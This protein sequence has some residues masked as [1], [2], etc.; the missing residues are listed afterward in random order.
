MAIVLRQSP[1]FP[2]E[3]INYKMKKTILLSGLI[4]L[5]SSFFFKSSAQKVYLS[6]Y[7][8]RG[9]KEG[10]RVNI[11]DNF[12]DSKSE[13]YLDVPR[14]K[15]F[16]AN[17]C[18]FI[19]ISIDKENLSNSN[20]LEVETIENDKFA[21]L[22]NDLPFEKLTCSDNVNFDKKVTKDNKYIYISG[23][24]IG[25]KNKIIFLNQ[26]EKPR[27][28]TV[29]KCNFVSF[30]TKNL[31]RLPNFIEINSNK[32]QLNIN[33]L[34][35]ND[36]RCYQNKTY[37]PVQANVI[38]SNSALSRTNNFPVSN[39][40]PI[41]TANNNTFGFNKN[42][43]NISKMPTNENICIDRPEMAIYYL[44]TNPSNI[45]EEFLTDLWGNIG[46]SWGDG[47]NQAN[48]HLKA[49]TYHEKIGENQYLVKYTQLNETKTSYTILKGNYQVI[50]S[51]NI[52][53]QQPNAIK[54]DIQMYFIKNQ[55]IN[56][57]GLAEPL[58]D[59]N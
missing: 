56:S 28:L 42:N 40:I 2:Y 45:S 12:L 57:F 49:N 34:S 3:N 18:G 21:I 24:P 41:L 14:L 8:N 36:V 22:V 29:N 38:T 33:S 44:H 5:A 1:T 32:F 27:N 23:L 58:K 10:Y 51:L 39:D 59:C 53:F 17:R 11:I 25:S 7:T 52:V 13:I 20:S 35:S 6:E 19:R 37:I 31:S 46:L 9:V 48:L 30:L 55:F 26:S 4:L 43:N 16:T 50:N 15:K 47:D 54:A